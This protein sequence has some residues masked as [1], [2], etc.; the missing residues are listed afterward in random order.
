M[1]VHS[2]IHEHAI[3]TITGSAE[4]QHAFTG[5]TYVY[6]VTGQNKNSSTGVHGAVTSYIHSGHNA[7]IV[8]IRH[9]P[10]CFN[11]SSTP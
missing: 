11:Q 2:S 5:E 4:T 10:Y 7:G 3:I 9:V 6:T 8:T 1:H